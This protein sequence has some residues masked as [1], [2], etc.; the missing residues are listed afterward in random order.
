ML[1]DFVG[2]QCNDYT[3][4]GVVDS[5][6]WDFFSRYLGQTC[7]T[8]PA[9]YFTVDLLT[10]PDLTVSFSALPSPFA[11]VLQTPQSSRPHSTASFSRLRAGV[12]PTRGRFLITIKPFYWSARNRGGQCTLH[13]SFR[14]TSP[15]LLSVQLRTRALALLRQS[16]AGRR[17]QLQSTP[18]CY[19]AINQILAR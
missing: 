4:D 11:P 10:R 9:D 18:N 14:R 7:I 5:R 6:D 8:G 3:N 12:S 13:D 16:S 1:F 19:W 2:D 17:L 15:W